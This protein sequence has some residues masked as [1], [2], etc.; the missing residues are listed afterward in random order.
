MTKI[1]AVFCL[2]SN[3]HIHLKAVTILLALL[4]AGL[5]T[6][7]CA[8][9][10]IPPGSLAFLAVVAC[11][12]FSFAILQA[13]LQ[14]FLE[15]T[16]KTPLSTGWRQL[17]NLSR[18]LAEAAEPE[19]IFIAVTEALYQAL[20]AEH[21]G[22]W[23]HNAQDNVLALSHYEGTAITPSLHDLPLD[24]DILQS[25]KPRSVAALPESALRHG[26]LE[27]SV[28]IISPMIWRNQLLGI[29]TI[30]TG[31][32]NAPINDQAA[33]FVTWITTQTTLAYQSIQLATELQETI[34]NLQLAYHQ[35]IDVQEEE[36]RKLAAE[37]HDD[38]LGRL[39]TMSL[40]LRSSRK[41]LSADPAQVGQWLETME[42][43]T[44]AVNLRLREITQGLHPS[45][46]IDL[47]MI[48]ALQAYVDSLARQPLPPSA[49]KLITLTAQGFG[50]QRVPNVKLERDLYHITRQALDNAV[51]H[52][53]ATQI[54]IHLRWSEDTISVTVQDTGQGMRDRPERLMGQRGHLG[55]LSMYERSRA[56]GGH[57]TIESIASRGTTVRVYV[58]TTQPS[59]APHHLQAFTQHLAR[60]EAA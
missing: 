45:V 35:T 16:A 29:I 58:P 18:V 46:L 28:D 14:R 54:Y 50:D 36:R 57:I 39:T 12:L 23:L 44:Q 10:S 24:Q 1:N 48:S 20:L 26:L 5:S 22:I 7:F 59:Q 30:G 27:N 6:L 19:N 25:P 15:E 11:T 38:I 3:R 53:H 31:N 8:V 4:L 32:Q 2:L 55:L 42:Q 41:R 21:I 40:T 13:V 60:M 52:A 34:T 17:P 9:F 49:P 33:Q 51:V 56:W 37:L 47:G 43:E